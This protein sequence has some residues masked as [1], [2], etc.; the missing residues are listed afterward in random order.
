MKKYI[1]TIITEEPSKSGNEDVEIYNIHINKKNK[2]DVY[3]K[4][5]KAILKIFFPYNE[6]QINR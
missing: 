6:N 3:N 2:I 4:I 1:I 5:Q